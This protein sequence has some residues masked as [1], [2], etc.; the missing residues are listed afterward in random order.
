MLT[1][2]WCGGVVAEPVGYVCVVELA[3]LQQQ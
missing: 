2:Q 1:C 3:E